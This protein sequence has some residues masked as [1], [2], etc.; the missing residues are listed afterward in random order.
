MKKGFLE[1]E[2]TPGE[3]VVKIIEMT[4]KDLEYYINLTDVG[5]RVWEDWHQFENPVGKILSNSII[6]YRK[7]IDEMK[8]KSMQQTL[9]LPYFKKLPEPPQPSPTTTLICQQPSTSR[10]GPP[11]AK[12][13]WLA[14]FS[15]III[16]IKIYTFFR[17]YDVAYLIDYSIV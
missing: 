4:V 11:P 15:N 13:L 3:E 1:M 2:A 17:H 6:Y 5:N 10:Q 7:D 9:S 16:L 8:G 14:F 12:R